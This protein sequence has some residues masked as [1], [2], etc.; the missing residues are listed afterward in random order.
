MK[1]NFI[2][3]QMVAEQ[4]QAFT[5]ASGVSSKVAYNYA[6]PITIPFEANTQGTTLSQKIT[7]SGSQLFFF[8]DMLFSSDGAFDIMFKDIATGRELAENLIPYQVLNYNNFTGQNF[9]GIWQFPMPKVMTGSSELYI[10]VMNQSASAN[11]VILNFN[12]IAINDK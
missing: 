12:G 3:N 2:L 1:D 6:Y 7:I 11:T 9:K 8:Q 5:D 10:T 4:L